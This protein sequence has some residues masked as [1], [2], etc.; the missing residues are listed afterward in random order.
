MAVRLAKGMEV[1]SFDTFRQPICKRG[2]GLTETAARHAGIVYVCLDHAAVGINAKT[3]TYRLLRMLGIPCVDLRFEAA[4]L[5][6]GIK[7][8]VGTTGEKL[9]ESLVGIDRAI[10][11]HVIAEIIERELHLVE[12]AGSAC[13][14]VSLYYREGLPKRVCLERH[15]YLHVGL[16]LYSAEELKVSLYAVFVYYII[17]SLHVN[18]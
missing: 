9:R 11:V 10:G 7:R 6:E 17:R 13:R 8:D 12:R 2:C 5:C 4:E 3:G 18:S 14:E 16:L 15:N 1:K